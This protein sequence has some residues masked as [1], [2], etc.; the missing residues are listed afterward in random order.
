MFSMV[1]RIE[2]EN[3][4]SWKNKWIL[5]LFIHITVCLILFSQTNFAPFSRLSDYD[6]GLVVLVQTVTFTTYIRPICLPARELGLAQGPLIISGQQHGRTHCKSGGCLIQMC[7]TKL[8]CYTIKLDFCIC[9]QAI[10]FVK[11]VCVFLIGWDPKVS[12]L[13]VKYSEKY[14]VVYTYIQWYNGSIKT[15]CCTQ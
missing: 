2:I 11:L 9:F 4:W 1:Y 14:I 12:L 8:V 7:S 5:K 10:P 15:T 3:E 13:L 6:I